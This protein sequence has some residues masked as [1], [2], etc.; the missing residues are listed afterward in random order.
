[1]TI[2]ARG[3]T[4]VG[5]G[6]SSDVV[7]M[8]NIILSADG[9]VDLNGTAI[10]LTYAG[11]TKEYTWQGNRITAPVQAGLQYTVTPGEVQGYRQPEPQTFTAVGGN[12]N[13]V[14]FQYE[15]LPPVTTVIFDSSISD[16]A[17][18][19]IV[20]PEVRDIILG[21]YRRCL[22]KK[23]AEGETTI[24]YLDNNNSNL[25]SDGSAAQLNGNEGDWMVDK[26]E[27]WYKMEVLDENRWAVH[28]S[29]FDAG[30]YIQSPRMLI[31]VTKAYNTGNKV[32]SR[33]GVTPTRSVSQ[34]NFKTYAAARGQ[35]Y[36]IIDYEC[37]C[38]IAMMFYAKYAN[39]DSQAVLGVGGASTTT[40]M[41]NT[42]SIGNNDTVNST[43]GYVSFLGI[44]GVHGGCYEW[45]DGVL[46]NS[47]RLW[48]ITNIDGSIREVQAGRSSGYITEIA[49]KNSDHFDVI[50]TVATGSSSTYF[51]D[52][53]SQ[54]SSAS[55]VLARSSTGSD[56]YGGLA[57]TNAINDSSYTLVSIGSRLVFRGVVR[58]ASSVA[59]FKALAVA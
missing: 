37:H 15:E 56:A 18:I 33:S 4:I 20:N 23:T 5:G 7:E 44:E 47:S 42:A 28:L 8:V 53:Y 6:M 41:G 13:T 48:T 38:M 25:Y 27:F 24:C 3:K 58:E 17:N 52:D 46:I 9:S 54:S 43:T 11:I 36:G 21:R 19:T 12:T 14:S 39:R 29:L 10:T 35:G 55:R 59:D 40:T 31:G 22:A 2:I 49:A 32:Y 1:M 51:A 57:S 45:V 34:A 16:P 50:P 26:P 30:S